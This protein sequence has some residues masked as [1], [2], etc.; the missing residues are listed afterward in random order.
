MVEDDSR[1]WTVPVDSGRGDNDGAALWCC[2]DAAC[3]AENL[4]M[5]ARRAARC[6]AAGERRGGGPDDGGGPAVRRAGASRTARRMWLAR[7]R[8]AAGARGME[9]VAGAEEPSGRRGVRR[10]VRREADRGSI[11]GSRSRS[12]TIQRPRFD[13]GRLK[14]RQTH[15]RGKLTSFFLDRAR[16][17]RK[18]N[19][20]LSNQQF[21]QMSE[22]LFGH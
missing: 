4:R 22:G 8:E 16:L 3:A 9:E 17:V 10:E 14:G 18:S 20:F 12:M 2:R 5:A 13:A 6:E 19:F 11:G 21:D 15:G 1:W 7:E